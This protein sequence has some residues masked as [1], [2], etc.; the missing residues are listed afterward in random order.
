MS[1]DCEAIV[2]ELDRIAR[3]DPHDLLAMRKAFRQA[4]ETAKLV[5]LTV[6]LRALYPAMPRST[7]EALATKTSEPFVRLMIG[8]ADRGYKVFEPSLVGWWRRMVATGQQHLITYFSWTTFIRECVDRIITGS[9]ILWVCSEN[10]DMFDNFCRTLTDDKAVDFKIRELLGGLSQASD[11]TKAWKEWAKAN[12]PDKGG[13]AET[14]LNTK[15]VYEEWLT[16]Q[17][18]Q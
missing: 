18:K 5:L 10:A 13:D 9:D 4:E 12:H 8:L 15:L 6:K 3:S 14:F 17:P 16:F 1:P 2:T 11:V 7:Y